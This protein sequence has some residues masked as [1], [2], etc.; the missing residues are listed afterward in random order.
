MLQ[1]DIVR[2]TLYG[3]EIVSLL[4]RRWRKRCVVQCRFS[5]SRRVLQRNRRVARMHDARATGVSD[6]SVHSSFRQGQHD[7]CF[8]IHYS[9][10]L[11]VQPNNSAVQR[12]DV[13]VRTVPAPP[14]QREEVRKT[15][16]N[17]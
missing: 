14:L 16:N 6:S 9:R 4:G 5:E 17:N 12:I 11:G 2:S 10:K 7:G 8:A 13:I 3:H 15:K 1:T